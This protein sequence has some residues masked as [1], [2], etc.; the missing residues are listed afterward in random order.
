[1]RTPLRHEP[2]PEED[3]VTAIVADGTSKECRL[4]HRLGSRGF[5][6][7]GSEQWEC[8]NDR[9]CKQ[10]AARRERAEGERRWNT[11]IDVL[12]NSRFCAEPGVQEPFWAY[13]DGEIDEAT[14][15]KALL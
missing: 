4:C 9:V 15:K 13:V 10:R 3:R 12:L 6:V 11:A 8:A 1:M 2:Q 5:L 7:A 14:L